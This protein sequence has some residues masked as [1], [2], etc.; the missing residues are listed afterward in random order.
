MGDDFLWSGAEDTIEEVEFAEGVPVGG[1]ECV[2]VFFES[3]A[4][5]RAKLKKGFGI[6][7]WDGGGIG[8]RAVGETAM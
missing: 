2:D 4:S 8:E 7:V 6:V 1:G 5:L 3:V